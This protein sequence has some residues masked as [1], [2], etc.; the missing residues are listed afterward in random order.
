MTY[1]FEILKQRRQK[2]PVSSVFLLSDGLDNG[3]QQ[4]VASSLI[5]CGLQ[6]SFTIHSFGFGSDHDPVL[7]NEIAKIKD[8][9]FY[10]VEK[11]D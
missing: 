5:G 1:S 10:F 9:S 8:G 4:K 6:D 7:M 3:A 2:N 11:I